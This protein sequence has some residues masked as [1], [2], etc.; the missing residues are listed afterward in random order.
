MRIKQK[1]CRVKGHLKE[2]LECLFACLMFYNFPL[3]T[4][5]GVINFPYACTW[6]FKKFSSNLKEFTR[7]P[8]VLSIKKMYIGCC[9][10]ILLFIFLSLTQFKQCSFQWGY[11]SNT[12]VY[13]FN[14]P[15]RQEHCVIFW[16]TKNGEVCVVKIFL[17]YF[18]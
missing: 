15:D 12:V 2:I 8:V 6:V 10:V 14:K 5:D 13:A 4:M 7:R 1:M 16:D 18:P 9:T 3:L 17:K 11:F